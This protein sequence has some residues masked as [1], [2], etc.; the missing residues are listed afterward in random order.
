MGGTQLTSYRDSRASALTAGLPPLLAAAAGL[1]A[2]VAAGAAEPA[3]YPPDEPSPFLADGAR[4]IGQPSESGRPWSK[5]IYARGTY[6]AKGRVKRAVLMTAPMQSVRVY[7]NGPL[8]L[9][10]HDEREAL[11]Q[12]ADVTERLTPGENLFAAKVH[13]IWRPAVYAQM[14]VEYE[15]GLVED[16]TT[17][18]GW[19]CACQPGENWQSDP[20]AAGDWRPAE[21]A[22]GYYRSPGDNIWGREFALLPRERLKARLDEHNRRLREAWEEDRQQTGLTLNGSP[23]EQRWAEQFDGFARVDERTGQ[24]IDGAGR[25]RHL[26]FT[27]YN[28][29]IDGRTV[30][31]V[32]EMD[33]DRLE[34]DLDLMAEAD[35]HL[36]LR[37]TGWNWLLTAEGDWAALDRQPAGS[38]LPEFSLGIELLEHLV[39][40]AYAHERYIVFEGDFYWGA[41]RDVVP[42]PYRSRYHLYPEVLEAQA[43]AMRKIMHRFRH[44]PN[45]LGMMIGEEDIVLAHDLQNP[46]QKALFAGFLNR[47]Y[48]SPAAFREHT[49]WGYNYGDRSGY[50]RAQR[51]PEYWPASEP[52]EVL[53]PR[54]EPQ[55]HPFA[56]VQEWLDI[57]LPL[58][59]GYRCPE[60]PD[61]V[62]AGFKSYNNFTPEDPL[63]IDFYEMREDELL[64]GMLCRWAEIVRQG[65][66][67]QLLFYSNAQDFTNSWH[68]L[69]LFRRA[70]LPFDV[71]GVGCHDSEKDLAELPPWAT[72]RKAIKVISSY[73]PYALAAGSPPRGVASGEGQGGNPEHPD[74]VLDYYRGALFDEI[75]GGA[76]WTQTYTWLHLSG[77]NTESDPHMTPLLRWLSAF[78][79]DAQGVAFPLKRPVHVLVV[80]NTNLQHSNMSGLDYGNVRAVAEALT[81]LNVEFD[82]AMDRDIAYGEH[83]FKVDVRPYRLIVLPSVWIDHP[84]AV[85]EVLDRW[86]SDEAYRGERVLAIGR[87]GLRGPRLQPTAEFPAMV[88]RWLHLDRYIDELELQRK[89]ELVLTHDG[90]DTALT[91]D[92]GSVPPTGVLDGDQPF[93]RTADGL[94]IG[95]RIAYSGNTIVA[96]GF[97]LGFAHDYLWGFEPEQEPRDAL[98]PLWEALAAEADVDRPVLAPHNLRVYVSGD[99]RLVLVRERAGVPTD[100]Q[101]AVRIPTGIGY[102]E[103]SI[104]QGDDGY[105]RLRVSLRPW[106]GRHFRAH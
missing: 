57:P 29:R 50:A 39:Q 24:L 2:A 60:E 10:G 5:V 72:V 58:W 32:P 81:Q 46:H 13:S 14:R 106:E 6:T 34:R 40:R 17:G 97:P 36:Y 4:W 92:F 59:P 61:V 63:W 74:E 47:K 62:L 86:L 89:Q 16:F 73:R 52:E 18:P 38:G 33:L 23:E 54:F 19:E 99:G 45:V 26:L 25:V 102:N 21:D 30:L 94:T 11:P 91:V 28:Q 43:L 7:I 95:C 44:C 76:A 87:V 1:L 56:R 79:P 96:F 42:A 66:P 80:R 71:I 78:M 48:G 27:I 41:H 37:Q 12:W 15:D 103:A 49:P 101:V 84:D 90:R 31:S 3:W 8:V 64:F 67:N 100:A 22:G 51:K 70:E 69:H 83:E 77:G 82:I 85:W 53:V 9:T 55:P 68:F 20:S 105:A 93:L 88:Q 98:A 104:T 75:G 35:V 65:M